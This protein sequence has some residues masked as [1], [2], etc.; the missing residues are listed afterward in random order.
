VADAPPALSARHALRLGGPALRRLRVDLKL[1]VASLEV[2]GAVAREARKQISALFDTATGGAD[3]EGW[4]LGE[5]PSGA[6]VAVALANVAHLESVA[7]VDLREIV[8]G[9]GDQPWPQTLK[10]NELA[11][12][13]KDGVRIDF[14]TIE[15]LA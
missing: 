10:R 6:D 9:G 5:S 1:R 11:R 8:P 2:A 12:L 13:E 14:E 7:T 15:V 4:T 3:K